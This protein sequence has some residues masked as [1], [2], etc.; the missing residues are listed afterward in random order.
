MPFRPCPLGCGRF[1]ST[2]DGHDRCLRCLGLQHA[3]AAFVDDS[4]AY[5][6]RTSMT[7]LR[8]RLS[9]LKGLTPSAATRPGLSV[10]SR[11]PPAG[12]L[13]DLRITVRASPPPPTRWSCVR[14]WL[15]CLLWRKSMTSLRSRL[16]F[17]KGLTP[18]AATRAGLSGSSRGPPAGALGDLR[19]TVRASPPGTS[20]RTSYSSANVPSGSQ[21]I[22]P[23]RP[24]GRQHFIR[25]AARRYDVDRSIRAWAYVLWGWRFGGAAPLGCCRHRR[26]GPRAEGHACPGSREYRAGGHACCDIPPHPG[27]LAPSSSSSSVPWTVNPGG[28]P[29][30]PPAVRLGGAGP[31]TGLGVRVRMAW[32]PLGNP[33]RVFF[34]G[35]FSLTVNL[36]LPFDRAFC[37]A[38]L[39]ALLPTPR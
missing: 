24:T 4:C 13:G 29:P 18:S 19:I 37:Q 25:C 26:T 2:D 1:L 39:A 23:V 7:S 10:S 34:H 6:G 20:P 11:G 8:S 3:E 28:V 38:L 32:F 27:I 15:M 14:G 12:T 21:V 31:C 33:I 17:L 35:K 22:L 5:C 16:S 30:A 36:C 9:F